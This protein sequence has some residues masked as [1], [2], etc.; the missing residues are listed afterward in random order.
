MQ[1]MEQFEIVTFYWM[2][3]HM[4]LQKTIAFV[5]SV[6]KSRWFTRVYILSK[7]NLDRSKDQMCL[8]IQK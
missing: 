1:F 5:D 3:Q 7:S 6:R 4:L 2:L 8:L